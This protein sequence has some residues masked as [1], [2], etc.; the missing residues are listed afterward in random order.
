MH[1][2]LSSKLILINTLLPVMAFG[3]AIDL[4]K[5]VGELTDKLVSVSKGEVVGVEGDIIYINLGQKEGVLEG[6][7]LEV[8][9]LGEP[10]RS[11]YGQ[12]LCRPPWVADNALPRDSHQ[13]T[14]ME[15]GIPTLNKLPIFFIL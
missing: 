9:R 14:P 13:G 1:K 3:Q 7:K 4:A 5:A 6:N 11:C 15:S 8:V 2:L 10:R 12:F